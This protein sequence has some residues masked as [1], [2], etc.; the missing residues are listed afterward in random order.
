MP[1]TAPKSNEIH[2]FSA[3]GRVVQP[4]H[5]TPAELAEHESARAGETSILLFLVD[6]ECGGELYGVIGATTVDGRRRVRRRTQD[7]PFSWT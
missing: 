7:V 6:F 3:A 1:M 4:D 2:S 5:V